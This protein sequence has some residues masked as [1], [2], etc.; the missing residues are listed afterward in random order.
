MENQRFQNPGYF[1]QDMNQ[2]SFPSGPNPLLQSHN[3]QQ[4]MTSQMQGPQYQGQHGHEIQFGL[5]NENPQQIQQNF[6][7]SGIGVNQ[8]NDQQNLPGIQ[9]NQ[10]QGKGHDKDGTNQQYYGPVGFCQNMDPNLQNNQFEMNQQFSGEKLSQFPKT[11]GEQKSDIFQYNKHDNLYQEGFQ[12]NETGTNMSRGDRPNVHGDWGGIVSMPSH[13]M[14]K[15]THPDENSEMKQMIPPNDIFGSGQSQFNPASMKMPHEEQFFQGRPDGQSSNW[16]RSSN[17]H[18]KGHSGLYMA[19]AQSVDKQNQFSQDTT[20]SSAASQQGQWPSDPRVKGNI[21]SQVW[22]ADELGNNAGRDKVFQ[23]ADSDLRTTNETETQGLGNRPRKSRF[24]ICPEGQLDVDIEDHQIRLGGDGR[25]P[26]QSSMS[27]NIGHAMEGADGRPMFKNSDRSIIQGTDGMQGRMFS[28]QNNVSQVTNTCSDANFY[29]KPL[30]NQPADKGLGVGSLSRVPEERFGKQNFDGHQMNSGPDFRMNVFP[31]GNSLDGMPHGRSL[32][33]RMPDNQPFQ[34]ES[35]SRFSDKDQHGTMFSRPYDGCQFDRRSENRPTDLTA[36][37]RFMGRHSNSGMNM[38]TDIRPADRAGE[39]LLDRGF[40]RNFVG[41]DGNF[42]QRVDGPVTDRGSGH[43]NIGPD[44]QTFGQGTDGVCMKSGLNDRLHRNP[45]TKLFN[46]EIDGNFLERGAG[47]NMMFM[48]ASG[49]PNERFADSR[50]LPIGDKRQMFN[51]VQSSFPGQNSENIFFESDSNVRFNNRDIDANSQARGLDDRFMDNTSNDR[52]FNRGPQC[53]DRSITNQ[54]GSQRTFEPG[55]ISHPFEKYQDGQPFMRR[56]D[57]VFNRDPP[58]TPDFQHNDAC[59]PFSREGNQDSG[60]GCGWAKD[61]NQVD[62]FGDGSDT[63]NFE[64]QPDGR[65]IQ[66]LMDCGPFAAGR[67]FPDKRR[68]SVRRETFDPSGKRCPQEQFDP[69]D[70]DIDNECN[71]EMSMHMDLGPRGYESH[72]RGFSGRRSRGMFRGCGGLERG[73]GRGFEHHSYQHRVDDGFGE[74]PMINDDGRN[75]EDNDSYVNCFSSDREFNVNVDMRRGRGG[76]ARGRGGQI[77]GP[78]GFR[79]RGDALRGGLSRGG[80]GR[81]EDVTHQVDLDERGNF[82]KNDSDLPQ[83]DNWKENVEFRAKG[84]GLLGDAPSEYLPSSSLGEESIDHQEKESNLRDDEKEIWKDRKDRVDRSR[85]DRSVRRF[86][87]R[88]SRDRSLERDRYSRRNDRDRYDRREHERDRRSRDRERDSGRD[89]SSIRERDLRVRDSK[90]LADSK[91]FKES[92]E[93]KNV[94][95]SKDSKVSRDLKEQKPYIDKKDAKDISF[96][97]KEADKSIKATKKDEQSSKPCFQHSESKYIHALGFPSSYNFREIR[98]FFEGCELPFDGIQLMVDNKG[99][100]TG[101]VFLK[102]VNVAAAQQALRKSKDSKFGKPITMSYIT[103]KVFESKRDLQLSTAGDVKDEGKLFPSVRK[104]SGSSNFIVM[105]Q[106]L[107]SNITKDDISKFF[108]SVKFANK[109]D[110]VCISNDDKSLTPGIGYVEVSSM[111]DFKMALSFDGHLLAGKEVKVSAGRQTDMDLHLKRVKNSCISQD[112]NCKE[113]MNPQQHILIPDTSGNKPSTV[114][115]NVAKFSTP[116][117]SQSSDITKA[118]SYQDGSIDK[119][120]AI[121]QPSLQP[122]SALSD[123]QRSSNCIHVQGLPMLASYKDIKEFFA[124]LKFVNNRG[125]QIMHD[126][127]G[128]PMGEGFVEFASAVDKERALKMDKKSM[129]RH[130][131]AVKAVAKVDMIERLKN[132]RLVG[133][134]AGPGPH[135]QI[136]RH[137]KQ[138]GGNEIM[139]GSSLDNDWKKDSAPG[140]MQAIPLHVLNRQLVYIS[141]QNF[142]PSISIS[143]IMNFFQDFNPIAESIRLHFSV[144]GNSTGKALVGF[145]KTD[146]ARRALL[147]L[148]GATCRRSVVTLMPLNGLP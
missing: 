67:G 143:E 104:D 129:G 100:R 38:P 130:I 74:Y 108:V 64:G 72:E 120:T 148:N 1:G 71:E 9:I 47:G 141:C 86:D 99:Q 78:P 23:M 103:D 121:R 122:D 81:F 131:L 22:E 18:E 52:S 87:R 94:K 58:P 26:N 147:T 25:T 97:S 135:S 88:R 89:R 39:V 92:R 70:M 76:M 56:P 93:S 107:P 20:T 36:D 119:S 124:D 125:I 139:R 33:E 63:Q 69:V 118:H 80:S 73:R 30:N 42:L 49:G 116:A 134:S 55:P 111:H 126:A 7:N 98:R 136:D 6:Q 13:T 127:M 3:M 84:R 53:V 137:A 75:M 115:Q 59:F 66:P 27:Q 35:N 142:P 105:I 68:G 10:Y 17:L 106:G 145:H 50:A 132:A 24:D 57:M 21:R 101:E 31:S 8:S 15:T 32:M 19:G 123:D 113:G 90:E 29:D 110:A 95:D 28:S 96:T 5:S 41:P 102:F 44:V 91:D 62:S 12:N 37:G 51:K 14:S 133:Q 11:G 83:R 54:G 34:H 109:E 61:S 43:F 146:D 117:S 79:G 77:S 48:P 144:D 2:E 46:Q 112:D 128:K 140:G 4:P 60:R 138:T 40:D 16:P 114:A 45:D 65:P 82:F 85:D